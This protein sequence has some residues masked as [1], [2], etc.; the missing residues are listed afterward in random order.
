MWNECKLFLYRPFIFKKVNGCYQCFVNESSRLNVPF[1]NN[2]KNAVKA[3]I[4][5]E[6]LLVF[7]GLIQ[8]ELR[9]LQQAKKW[10]I[11]SNALICCIMKQT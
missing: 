4:D 11:R 9:Q 5:Y 7:S 3:V 10:I 6:K 1:E 8:A 2:Q